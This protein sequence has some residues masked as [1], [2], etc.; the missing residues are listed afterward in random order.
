M[1]IKFLHYE[2][3]EPV[4]EGEYNQKTFRAIFVP[5]DIDYGWHRLSYLPN[6]QA[7]EDGW[8]EFTDDEYDTVQ[9]LLEETDPYT[10]VPA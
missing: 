3:G 8:D 9:E 7:S 2:N 6:Y 4:F 1:N 5:T 10:L